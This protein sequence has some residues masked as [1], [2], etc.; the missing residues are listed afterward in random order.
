VR[1]DEE[2]LVAL[3]KVE[4]RFGHGRKQDVEMTEKQ[5]AVT[6]LAENGFPALQGFK[7]AGLQAGQSRLIF[8]IALRDVWA[9]LVRTC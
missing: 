6:A 8:C 5:F 4:D 1:G 2:M 3:E 9:V 7:L